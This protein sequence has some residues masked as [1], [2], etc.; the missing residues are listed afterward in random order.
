MDRAAWGRWR[1][2]FVALM[3]ALFVGAMLAPAETVVVGPKPLT[4]TDQAVAMGVNIAHSGSVVGSTLTPPLVLKWTRSFPGYVSYPLMAEGRVFVTAGKSKGFQ[5][6]GTYLYALDAP[7]GRTLW[8]RSIPGILHWSEAAYD[9][10]RVFVLNDD[11]LLSAFDAATGSTL[12]QVSLES[13]D[14][15]YAPTAADGIVYVNGFY[16]V[17]EETGDTLWIGT[18]EGATASS[19]ALS[20]SAVFSVDIG[21]HIGAWN[22]FT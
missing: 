12:W 15:P 5:P 7:T 14:Q 10:G 16:A 19:P 8:R 22:R 21:P 9:A 20:N 18:G 13:A 4:V 2:P 11:T 3:A 6:Y 17:S 1:L